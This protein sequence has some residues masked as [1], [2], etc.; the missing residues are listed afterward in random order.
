[1]AMVVGMDSSDWHRMATALVTIPLRLPSSWMMGYLM[2]W[3]VAS[4]K[5]L[6]GREVLS[7][8][9]KC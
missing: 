3:V 1:M 8:V 9:K 2:R 4:R 5:E 7:L 6:G